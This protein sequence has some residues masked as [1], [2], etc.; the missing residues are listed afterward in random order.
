MASGTCAVVPDESTYLLLLLRTVPALRLT[1][2][3]VTQSEDP[4]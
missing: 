4:T 1:E 3:E 2:G